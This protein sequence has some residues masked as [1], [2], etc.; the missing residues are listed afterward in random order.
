MRALSQSRQIEYMSQTDLLT[1]TK[2]RNHYENRLPHYTEICDTN[3]ICVYA[4]VN[5]LH[6]MNNRDG[7]PAGDRMLREA[8]KAMQQHFGEED[9]YRVGGD[10]FIAF[11][12]N[13]DP[14]NLPSE[15]ES[16][17]EDLRKKGYN[18]SFGFAVGK[19]EDGHLDMFHLVSTAESNM[20]ADKRDFYRR[21]ENDR[22]SR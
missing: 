18:V 7:H 14:G 1:G 8:A 16:L 5:G 17:K 11:R 21:S 19:K 13:S 4:D 22:R 2:N 10:E 15:I 6:E 20:F 3:L 9:T 12:A